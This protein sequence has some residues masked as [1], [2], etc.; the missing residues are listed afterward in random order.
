MS[1]AENS[2]HLA[3]LWTSCDLGTS[4]V[5]PPGIEKKKKKDFSKASCNLKIDM[6][7]KPEWDI[8]TDVD[9]RCN[10]VHLGFSKTEAGKEMRAGQ[11]FRRCW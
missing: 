11:Q 10:E 4:S 5:F 8:A 1:P 2:H 6:K 3:S 7:E 9:L